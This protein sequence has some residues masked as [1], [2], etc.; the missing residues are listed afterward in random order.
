M[1]DY[2]AQQDTNL[3]AV[4]EE[5]GTDFLAAISTPDGGIY[6]Y[7][8]YYP[9]ANNM[10]KYRAWMNQTWL[11][12]LGLE[13]PTTPDELYEVL[14]AFKEQ[15]ANGN[16]DPNDEIPMLGCAAG[17]STDPTPFLISAFVY[18]DDDLMLNI[19]EDGQ[20]SPAY[21]SEKYR[22]GLAFMKKLVDEG[23]ACRGYFFHLLLHSIRNT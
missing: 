11:D 12:N 5:V 15:D 3:E 21:V 19:D 13:Q 18:W 16:G 4:A 9:E 10:T 17:W 7:P 23:L 8:I 6:G 22:E 14:K 2:F 20:I 1:A